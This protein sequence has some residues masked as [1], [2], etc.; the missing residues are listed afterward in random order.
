MAGRRRVR[1][2]LTRPARRIQHWS[3]LLADAPTIEAELNLAFDW[4]RS[5]ARRQPDRDMRI[6]TLARQLAAEAQ[7]MNGGAR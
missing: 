5:A 7:A 4:W 3:G 1:G 2:K 6:I